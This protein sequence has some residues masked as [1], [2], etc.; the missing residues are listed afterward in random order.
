MAA[1]SLRRWWRA[2]RSRKVGAMDTQCTGRVF[3]VEDSAPIRS[4]L[5]EM[6]GAVEGLC[7]VG[8]AESPAEAVAGISATRPDCVVLDF[9]LIGGTA[10]DVL[11]AVHPVSP[12]IA[13][14][15]LTNHPTAQYRRACMEAGAVGFL[16]KSTEFGKLKA[17]VAECMLSRH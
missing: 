15:V 9:Q 17:A 7:V 13:F 16:D 2:R 14:I 4:R 11:R 3:I 8:E 12:E 5:V 10:V 1:I 6:L